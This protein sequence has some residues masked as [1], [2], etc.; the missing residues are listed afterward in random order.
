MKPTPVFKL[1]ET[2]LQTGT[3]LVEASAGTGKTFTIGGLFLRLILERKISVRE[4]LVVTYTTAAT[5]ELR[6][7]VR[8]TLAKALAAFSQNAT[9]DPFLSA[10]LKKHAAERDDLVVRLNNALYGFDEAPIYTIHGF[11]QRFDVQTKAHRGSLATKYRADF[12]IAPAPRQRK[13]SVRWGRICSGNAAEYRYHVSQALPLV[14]SLEH[15][16]AEEREQGDGRRVARRE[17]RSSVARHNKVDQG[18]HAS[19][20]VPGA[21]AALKQGAYRGWGLP[22]G[23]LRHR[24]RA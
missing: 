4:I 11:C 6:H 14:A 15:C 5:E 20:H 1:A 19:R 17:P 21:A 22:E 18:Q 16:L 10:L 9:D 7:R 3:T 13:Q 23:I 2:P 24:R 12:V 8:Q